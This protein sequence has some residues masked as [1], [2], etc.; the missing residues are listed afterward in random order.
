MKRTNTF[1]LNIIK[2]Q[3]SRL[4]K[5]ADNCSKMYNEVNYKRRQS[6]FSGKIDW[7]TDELYFKYTGI[8]D[9]AT[10]QQIIIKNNEA[11]KYFFFMLKRKEYGKLSKNI[12]KIGVPGY[13]K[14]RKTGERDVRIIIR[15]NCYKLIGDILELPFK[16]SIKWRGK[17]KWHGEQGRL[18]IAY[19]KLSHRWYAFQ[20][21][22]VKPPH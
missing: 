2:E 16:L 21:V 20:P 14:Y 11:W 15:N 13:L 18:E 19:D 1:L 9:S 12:K 7:N 6:F 5:L 17:N 8:V 4:F 10:T 3:E 22:K